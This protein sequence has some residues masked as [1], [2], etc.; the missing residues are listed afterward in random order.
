MIEQIRLAARLA[1]NV[2]DFRPEV[3]QIVSAVKS[4]GPELYS[5]CEGIVLSS[6]DLK[7]ACIKRYIEEH[8][9]TR[10]EAILMTLDSWQQMR[11]SL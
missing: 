2:E 1:K 11:E 6:V 7:A 10:Q 8:G 5:L 3:K 9:F 4:F